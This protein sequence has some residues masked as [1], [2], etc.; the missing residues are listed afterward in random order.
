MLAAGEDEVARD[1]LRYLLEECRDFV[2][3]HKLLAEIALA[4]GDT[5]LSRAHF[6]F[7]FEIGRRAFP[8]TGL[9]GPLPYSLPGNQPFLEAAKGLAWCLK[10]LGKPAEAQAVTQQLLACDPSDPLGVAK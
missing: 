6:G 9:E 8:G 2:E 3:A 7:A 10:E 5:K 4:E 1:E